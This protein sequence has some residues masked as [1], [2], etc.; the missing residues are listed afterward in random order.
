MGL[1]TYGFVISRSPVRSR[2]VAPDFH[3]LA[4]PSRQSTFRC[5]DNSPRIDP[6]VQPILEDLHT[7]EAIPHIDKNVVTVGLPIQTGTGGPECHGTM[8]L[9]CILQRIR[10]LVDRFRDNHDLRGKDDTELHRSPTS[11]GL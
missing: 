7:D 5:T 1:D 10:D 6:R 4:A 2:R 11:R 9:L 3:R 8:I